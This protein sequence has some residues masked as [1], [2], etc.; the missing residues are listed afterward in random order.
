MP[1]LEVFKAI[2]LNA[3]KMCGSLKMG[4]KIITDS[5][6]KNH[7]ICENSHSKWSMV[8]PLF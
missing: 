4:L 5:G 3:I 6:S 2:I 7:K 8:Y 1:E